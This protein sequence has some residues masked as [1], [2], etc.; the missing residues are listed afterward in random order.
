MTAVIDSG[1]QVSM[2]TKYFC[3]QY[4]MRMKPLRGLLHL[5]SIGVNNAILELCKS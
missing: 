3:E 5:E 2:I 1:A 4:G